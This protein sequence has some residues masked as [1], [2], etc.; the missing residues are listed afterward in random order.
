M[1]F[2]GYYNKSVILTYISVLSAVCGLFFAF[3]HQMKYGLLALMV[4]GAC[5]LVDGSV[6]RRCERSEKQENFGIQLDS[7]AD[8]VGFL[9]LPS[10]LL[11]SL[12]GN[13]YITIPVLGLYCVMGVVRLAW[14]NVSASS[15]PKAFQGL[16]VTQI[17]LVL[18]LMYMLAHV[19][20]S[21]FL[22]PFLV[23][24][25]LIEAILF[26]LNVRIPKPRGVVMYVLLALFFF[27]GVGVVLL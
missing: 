9:A 4:S 2:I 12:E 21:S 11:L 22:H 16:P 6:A 1:K 23:V 13:P 14:F 24:V 18:P 26:V 15:A 25:F 8:T 7:L 10:A 3:E 17:A 5:D 20:F 19:F 27:T